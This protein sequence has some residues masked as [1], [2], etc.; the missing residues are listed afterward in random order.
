MES[1]HFSSLCLPCQ[2]M[3]LR[4]CPDVYAVE[5]WDFF[6][7][8]RLR[9]LLYS[10]ISVLITCLIY[11]H[12]ALAFALAAKSDIFLQQRVS[13]VIRCTPVY[14]KFSSSS[15]FL[16]AL[17]ITCNITA[18]KNLADCYIV[19]RLS[20]DEFVSSRVKLV[21]NKTRKCSVSF[22]LSAVRHLL[23][24]LEVSLT[25]FQIPYSCIVT[26]PLCTTPA[27]VTEQTHFL[28]CLSCLYFAV[29]FVYMF[30][31]FVGLFPK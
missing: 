9:S 20:F 18:L 26:D 15:K 23:F 27:L 8:G 25:L 2:K 14:A 29:F 28:V 11:T 6:D 30:A 12:V 4:C 19:L 17:P 10:R 5:R 13:S 31:L 1:R 22:F 7:K 16:L 21:V 24:I 3:G